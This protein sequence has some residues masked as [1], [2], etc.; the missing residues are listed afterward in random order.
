MSY[1]ANRIETLVSKF[2]FFWNRHE[3]PKLYTITRLDRKNKE[4][5]RLVDAIM[6]EMK[7][8][9]CPGGFRSRYCRNPRVNPQFRFHDDRIGSVSQKG[10]R[11]GTIGSYKRNAL[12]AKKAIP[13]DKKFAKLHRYLGAL[14]RKY[15]GKRCA[16]IRVNCNIK[17]KKHKDSRNVG[18]STILG[19][20]PYTG[21]KVILTPDKGDKWTRKEVG[22][23]G[24]FMQFNSTEITHSTSPFKGKRYS[25]VFFDNK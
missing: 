4:T 19:L 24:A 11:G 22:I 16:A 12:V 17:A 5:N 13:T 1:E 20:G 3:M 10:S 18:I 21:G 14:Y 2:L 9:D 6:S 8:L 25:F 15:M 7:A 23:K